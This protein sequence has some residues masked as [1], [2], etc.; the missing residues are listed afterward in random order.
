MKSTDLLLINIGILIVADALDISSH[1]DCYNLTCWDIMYTGSLIYL[2]QLGHHCACR[3]SKTVPSTLTHWGRDKMADIFQATFSH[4]FVD[5]FKRIFFNENVS[6]FIKISLKFVPKGPIN[7]IL[8]LVQ[9]MVWHC[10]GEKPL[11]EPMMVRLSKHISV[12]WP[13]WVNSLRP[14][15]A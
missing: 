10:P 14:S 6:I 1:N 15:D 7:N 4:A 8:A 11:S 3:C 12:T 2:D 13:Q 5:I 9:I